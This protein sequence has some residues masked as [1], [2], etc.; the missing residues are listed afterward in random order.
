M[1][2]AWVYVKTDRL[3]LCILVHA[4]N[5]SLAMIFSNI[6]FVAIPGLTVEANGM[7]IKRAI[8]DIVGV[9]MFA[10]GLFYMKKIKFLAF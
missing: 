8:V 1:I 5:N 2:L 10:V 7:D 3:I 4:S 6:T 9:V